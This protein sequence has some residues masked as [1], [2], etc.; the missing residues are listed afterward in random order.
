MK[1]TPPPS[2]LQI[3]DRLACTTS[4]WFNY[5]QK[6][7]PG[8]LEG[9]L[10]PGTFSHVLMDHQGGLINFGGW[11]LMVKLAEI[12]NFGGIPFIS[13][14]VFALVT[15]I[16][17][18]PVLPWGPRRHLELWPNDV[19]AWQMPKRYIFP[20]TRYCAVVPFKVDRHYMLGGAVTLRRARCVDVHLGT[21][22]WIRTSGDE[23]QPKLSSWCP[24]SASNSP[25]SVPLTFIIPRFAGGPC[26]LVPALLSGSLAAHATLSLPA[27]ATLSSPGCPAVSPLKTYFHNIPYHSLHTADY[28]LLKSTHLMNSFLNDL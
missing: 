26:H 4:P 14:F 5:P 24:M 18:S 6:I 22:F 25:R 16:N 3:N 19:E 1:W 15:N 8:A 21:S 2:P 17:R 9:Y 27:L 20:R 7:L 12:Y 11:K 10:Y 23:W 28:A 13:R